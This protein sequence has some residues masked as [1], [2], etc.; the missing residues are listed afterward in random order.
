ML[1]AINMVAARPYSGQ[2][3]PRWKPTFPIRRP[4]QYIEILARFQGRA[5]IV[6]DVK[7]S[8]PL[9]KSLPVAQV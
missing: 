9:K 1:N 3:N 5:A 7:P 4:R 8:S 6:G 2:V